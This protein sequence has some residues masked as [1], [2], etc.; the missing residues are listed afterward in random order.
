MVD[1]EHIEIDLL[2]KNSTIKIDLTKN[3]QNKL[4]KNPP[5]MIVNRHTHRKRLI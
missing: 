4:T 2:T 3:P 5:N 1:L